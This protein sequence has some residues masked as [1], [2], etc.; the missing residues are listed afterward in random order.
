MLSFDWY[1]EAGGFAGRL[2]GKGLPISRPC[3]TKPQRPNH[4]PTAG[5]VAIMRIAVG[6]RVCA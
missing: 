5:S 2:S 4:S 3:H 6:R 1:R